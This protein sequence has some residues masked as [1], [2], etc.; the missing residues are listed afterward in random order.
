MLLCFVLYVVMAASCKSP[1]AAS[2]ISERTIY[3]DWNASF[4]INFV[5]SCRMMLM[6]RPN[7]NVVA[8]VDIVPRDLADKCNHTDQATV[9]VG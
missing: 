5:D 4:D 3:P 7:N 6:H 8:E 1:P 9:W 2:L